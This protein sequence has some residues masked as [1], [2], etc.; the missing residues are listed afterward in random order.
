MECVRI[1]M[2]NKNQVKNA[3]K[4]R[5]SRYNEREQLLPAT[6]GYAGETTVPGMDSWCYARLSSGEVIPV[7]NQVTAARYDLAVWVRQGAHDR[8]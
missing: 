7:Y 8:D 5:L 6:L 4:K 1:M 3:I 2:N